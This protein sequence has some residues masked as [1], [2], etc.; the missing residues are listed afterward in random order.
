VSVC[1]IAFPQR[2]PGRVPPT[3]CWAGD[4]LPLEPFRIY[5][6]W[7]PEEYEPEPINAVNRARREAMLRSLGASDGRLVTGLVQLIATTRGSGSTTESMEE[8]QAFIFPDGRLSQAREG[9]DHIYGP[10]VIPAP[11]GAV[12]TVHTHPVSEQS[13]APPSAG[14]FQQYAF[15]DLPIQLVVDINGGAW[16]VFDQ[17]FMSLLGHIRQGA[18][19]VLR[20]RST[21]FVYRIVS[22]QRA[23]DRRFAEDEAQRREQRDRFADAMRQLADQRDHDAEERRRRHQT[24]MGPIARPLPT[25]IDRLGPVG[26]GQG[27]R[28]GEQ[29]IPAR[30]L[31]WRPATRSR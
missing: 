9:H 18:F 12:G 4:G 26:A 22:G 19:V 27:R 7:G 31:Q 23:R 24:V 30:P 28:M 14:D 29:P 15:H 6:P 2:T 1:N 3:T 8:H 25:A 17:G 10:P 11:S 21:G 5:L 20:H 13:M 16:G